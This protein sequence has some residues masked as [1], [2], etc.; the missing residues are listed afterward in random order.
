MLANNS[1]E[2]SVTA[3]PASTDLALAA[4]NGVFSPSLVAPYQNFDQGPPGPVIRTPH[5]RLPF[6]CS[7][8]GRAFNS[9]LTVMRHFIGCVKRNGNPNAVH[10]DDALKARADLMVYTR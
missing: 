10:W 9:K 8:C 7:R 4:V 1:N 2:R 5:K 6:P 3:G